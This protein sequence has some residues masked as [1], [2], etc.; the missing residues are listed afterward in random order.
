MAAVGIIRQENGIDPK[1]SRIPK[2]LNLPTTIKINDNDVQIDNDAKVKP[3]VRKEPTEAELK[4]KG[5]QERPGILY[6]GKKVWIDPKTKKEY[7]YEN[8]TFAERPQNTKPTK[9]DQQLNTEKTEKDSNNKV[10][11]TIHQNAN[12]G[13]YDGYTVKIVVDGQEKKVTVLGS[14]MIANGNKP[15]QPLFVDAN[16]NMYSIDAA[17]GAGQKADNVPSNGITLYS[18]ESGSKANHKIGKV[19]KTNGNLTIT[20]Y[21]DQNDSK[22]AHKTY[23]TS[24]GSRMDNYN[25]TGVLRSRLFYDKGSRQPK[26]IDVFRG[27]HRARYLKAGKGEYVLQNVAI[28]KNNSYEYI[29]F[30]NA[31]N[32]GFKE[33]ITKDEALSLKG[34]LNS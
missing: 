11:S 19:E 34:L 31:N 27:E 3:A 8:G 29:N 7:T 22:V 16:G 24:T 15:D 18:G 30:D 25:D 6:D 26:S 12:N 32:L 2:K 10:L 4:A 14:I 5:L 23:Y 9:T 17:T 33:T 28:R 21:Q 20:R 13:K 1:S